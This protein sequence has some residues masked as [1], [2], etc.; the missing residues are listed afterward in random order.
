M[1]WSTY[2]QSTCAPPRCI[3][4]HMCRKASGYS[5]K[6]FQHQ[7]KNSTAKI[8][9]T[10]EKTYEIALISLEWIYCRFGRIDFLTP[11][12]I[13]LWK[14][15]FDECVRNL[16]CVIRNW[17]MYDFVQNDLSRAICYSF[18]ALH[19]KANAFWKSQ[20]FGSY[21]PKC[22]RKPKS[23]VSLLATVEFS[24]SGTQLIVSAN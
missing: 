7:K 5:I 9:R 16:E 6:Q 4:A 3:T 20:K 21:R 18:Y 14:K 1:I 22:N 23:H 11:V 19:L 15:V 2:N 13:T 12:I 8:T 17:R 10:F 24:F